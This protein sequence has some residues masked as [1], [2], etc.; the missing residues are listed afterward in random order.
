M[1]CQRIK[2]LEVPVRDRREARGGTG[3]SIAGDS[4]GTRIRLAHGNEGNRGQYPPFIK[5]NDNK[6]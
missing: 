1:A 6:H 3:G 5:S 4:W 2:V